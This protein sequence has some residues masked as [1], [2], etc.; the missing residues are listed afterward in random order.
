M[1][2]IRTYSSIIVSIRGFLFRISF[3]LT[4]TI[5]Y[6]RRSLVVV[7]MP[8]WQIMAAIMCVLLVDYIILGL[9]E[10]LSPWSIESDWQLECVSEYY[11]YFLVIFIV[12]NYSTVPFAI[13]L[14]WA[15]RKVP[16]LYNGKLLL[17]EIPCNLLRVQNHTSYKVSNTSYKVSTG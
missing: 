5:L 6:H 11:E 1:F 17:E 15:V 14:C 7:R 8:D 4:R 9:W 16:S 10:L 2:V 12:I 13:F 3:I